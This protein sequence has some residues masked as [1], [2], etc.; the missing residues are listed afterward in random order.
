MASIKIK[1]RAS[2]VIDKEGVVY[3]QVIHKRVVRMLATPYHINAS[4]WDAAAQCVLL[5]N[6]VQNADRHRYLAGVSARLDAEYRLLCRIAA[7]FDSKAEEYSTDSIAN[8]Y[9]VMA[10]EYTLTAFM[11]TI[12]TQMQ[13]NGQYCTAR[14]YRSMLNS[15]MRFLGGEDLA[16]DM[17]DDAMVRSYEAWMKGH[18]ICRN[19]SSFYMRILRA[20]YNR[21]VESGLVGQR[22]PFRH[23]YTGVDKTRKRAVDFDVIKSLRQMDLHGNCS[24]CFARDMFIMS[25]CLR[26][27]SFVDLAK[28]RKTDIRGGYL[29]YTRSKTR[30]S[31][32][33]KWEPIMQEM[34]DKYKKQ[35]ESSEFL[36]PI[37]SSGGAYNPDGSAYNSDGSIYNKVYHNAQMRVGYNLKS[38]A[39]QLGLKENLTLYAARHSW[40]T[41]ARDSNV[42][43]SVISEALGHDSELTTQIY[44]QSIQTSEVDKANAHILDAL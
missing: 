32:C 30:Q 40:A 41:V 27:I 24:Q 26:G 3:F 13:Q 5:E 4:E 9:R 19:T 33:V 34:V 8:K 1:F 14:N 36:F 18:G 39:R 16:L 22:H 35:M 43:I 44:L 31:L 29:Y 42:P 25:F 17:M 38:I 2:S 23:V 11:N 15:F 12:I 21:A 7:S 6:S 10:K 28:L 37:L 20:V